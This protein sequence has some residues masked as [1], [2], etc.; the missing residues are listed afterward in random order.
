MLFL[1]FEFDLS[2]TKFKEIPGLKKKKNDGSVLRPRRTMTDGGGR[3]ED[4][5]CLGKRKCVEKENLC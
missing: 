1:G 3:V 4:G 5:E 2:G